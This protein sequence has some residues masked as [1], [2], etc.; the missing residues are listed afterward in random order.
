MAKIYEYAVIYTPIKTKDQLERGE[1]PK[2]SLV[3]D[4]TRVLCDT[5]KEATLL[6][7]RAIPPDYADKLNQC[8]IAVRP[9]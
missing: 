5:D 9:F 1:Q 6:A 8:E 4:V 2:S 7:S 3:V